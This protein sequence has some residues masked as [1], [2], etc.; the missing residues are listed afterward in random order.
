LRRELQP[1]PAALAAG[2]AHVDAA[3]VVVAYDPDDDI[4]GEAEPT[5]LL[6]RFDAT[7][8]VIGGNDLAA[9]GCHPNH[10]RVQPYAPAR[11]R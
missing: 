1:R 4:V 10:L 9:G 6:T 7:C 11:R 5:A 8:F 3:S 2:G